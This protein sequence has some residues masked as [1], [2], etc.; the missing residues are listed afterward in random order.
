MQEDIRPIQT[1][2]PPQLD[3]NFNPIPLAKTLG[4][5]IRVTAA[6]TRVTRSARSNGHIVCKV[7]EDNPDS[8]WIAFPECCVSGYGLPPLLNRINEPNTRETVDAVH[9]I[10]RVQRKLQTGLVLGTAWVDRD[11][12]PYNSARI[13][14]STGY[15]ATYNKQLLTTTFKGGGEVNA[16]SKGW[17]NVT[18]FLDDMKTR[19]AGVL[20]CN[21]FFAH[22]FYTPKGDP[23]LSWQLA[24]EGA[25][26]LFVIS[27]TIVRGGPQPWDDINA[28]YT[29][30]KLETMART[31]GLWIV[32]VNACPEK[33]E[34]SNHISPTGIMDP[35]GNWVA[36][37]EPNVAGCVT[38]TITL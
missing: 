11:G 4:N 7:I 33:G 12:M 34:G 36:K 10:E 37:M 22:P 25:G 1:F 30:S 38:H 9:N 26:L 2:V 17:E 31:T 27:N 24:R 14:D 19:K 32:A 29:E 18:F 5:T 6:Q 13:Y 23:Y 16:W 3:E 20:I 15:R 8:D 21:D 35:Q 28:R